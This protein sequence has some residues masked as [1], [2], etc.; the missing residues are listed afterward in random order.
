MPNRWT[1]E[2]QRTAIC[3]YRS[4]AE[5][6]PEA[7]AS[8]LVAT[9]Q[10]VL[11]Q[12]RRVPEANRV[13][14]WLAFT[15]KQQEEAGLTALTDSLRP[16]FATIEPE[17]RKRIDGQA[18]EIASRVISG[19][20]ADE[21]LRGLLREAIG[22]GVDRFA[23]SVR[24]KPATVGIPNVLLIGIA[25]RLAGSL[26]R[27]FRGRLAVSHWCNG[28]T[29][30]SLLTAI[31]DADLVVISGDL[32]PNVERVVAAAGQD[33]AHRVS[34]PTDLVSTLTALATSPENLRTGLCARPNARL[35]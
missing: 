1:K 13:A 25:A 4:A 15:A 3:A 23:R 8:Q 32:P 28:H 20:I 24:T 16:W 31:A 14:R 19:L 2:E 17:L 34:H 27:Q 22:N 21:A 5:A 18:V 26:S 9:A 7:T 6:H 30:L 10:A 12:H 35:N 29:L 11:P 33:E